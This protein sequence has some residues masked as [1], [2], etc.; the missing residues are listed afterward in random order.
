M[1]QDFSRAETE[2][3]GFYLSNLGIAAQSYDPDG[4]GGGTDSEGASLMHLEAMRQHRRV[5]Q[6]IAELTPEHRHTL[7]LVYA[8]HRHPDLLRVAFAR[9]HGSF[10][11]LA[12]RTQ[13][14]VGAATE[15]HRDTDA[16]SVLVWLDAQ[17][18]K[19]EHAPKQ[20]F[21][22]IVAECDRTLKAAL[23]AYDAVR[24]ERV[25][26]E[27]VARREAAEREWNDYAA[28]ARAKQVDAEHQKRV[29][30]IADLL[31]PL[32]ESIPPSAA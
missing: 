10:V 29:S 5:E 22:A 12:A 26:R 1:G 16:A 17:A 8:P 13:A 2:L 31:R 18:R 14:V 3:V 4:H 6:T 32:V 24:R 11:A 28:R 9:S 15:A 21:R 20:L 7:W 19:G 27:K 23:T 30:D 25:E